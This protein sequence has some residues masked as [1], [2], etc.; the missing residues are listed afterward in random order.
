MCIG[1]TWHVSA[2]THRGCVRGHNEDAIAIND[3][4]LSGNLPAPLE[5]RFDDHGCVLMVA[6]GLGGH[7][8]GAIA[9]RFIVEELVKLINGTSTTSDC[10]K[11]IAEANQ[12]LDDLTRQQ[13]EL[14]GMGSTLVGVVLRQSEM[15]SFYVGDSRL[16]LQTPLHLVRLT[17]DDVPKGNVDHQG[18]RKTHSITQALGGALQFIAVEPHVATDPLPARGENLLLCSDGLTDLVSDDAI[19]RVL[20]ASK[21]PVFATRH[22]AALAFR[23][24]GYDNIS[25]VVA[26]RAKS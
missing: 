1:L 12:N 19:R 6:D 8:A 18:R 13:P 2:F 22:L 7:N 14:A 9:S 20:T 26:R 15:V 10:A 4:I 25:I 5:F 16:Y 24:G 17:Q 3:Q 23:R 11:A 21:N